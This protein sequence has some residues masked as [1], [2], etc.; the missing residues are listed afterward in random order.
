MFDVL[1][2]SLTVMD[3]IAVVETKVRVRRRSLADQ[4]GRAAE[5][6][7]LCISEGRKRA[8]LDRPDLYRKA[9]GSAD[10]LTTCLRIARS[11]GYISPADFAAVDEAL[12]RVRAMLWRLTH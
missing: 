1:E 5:S 2:V 3:R 6:I 12:D 4:L 10:E 7:S 11:R 8:G 9:A